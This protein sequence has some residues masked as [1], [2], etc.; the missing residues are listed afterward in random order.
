VGQSRSWHGGGGEAQGKGVGWKNL[1]GKEGIV[2]PAIMNGMRRD[3][4]KRRGKK[5]GEKREKS[6]SGKEPTVCM[7]AVHLAKKVR[8]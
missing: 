3:R 6:D 1:K 2:S 7:G 8:R 5:G 4:A